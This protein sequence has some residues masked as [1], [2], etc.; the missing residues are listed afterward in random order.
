MNIPIIPKNPNIRETEPSRDT[1]VKK[2]LAPRCTEDKVSI[3]EDSKLASRLI[4]K[5]K[6][7]QTSPKND[8]EELKKQ[9]SEGTY[10]PSSNDIAKAI[11]AKIS[12][13]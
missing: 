13:E 9:V 6:A 5:L 7:T 2:T 8:I 12:E 3:G 1:A 10:N 4:D 11:L